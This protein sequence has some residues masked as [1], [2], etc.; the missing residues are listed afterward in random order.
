M[1]KMQIN[2]TIKWNDDNEDE[3]DDDKKG[4]ERR[5]WRDGLRHCEC[6]M[7]TAN[8]Q[9][10]IHNPMAVLWIFKRMK[11]KTNPKEN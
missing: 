3:D 1:E 4:T 10:G 2:I 5:N 6:Q 8:Y 11:E 7:L 9:Q